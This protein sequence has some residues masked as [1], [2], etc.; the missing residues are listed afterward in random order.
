MFRQL[1]NVTESDD[2]V[3]GVEEVD[4]ASFD[5]F[6]QFSIFEFALDYI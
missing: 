4:V 3:A 1:L 5:I 6:K 2:G